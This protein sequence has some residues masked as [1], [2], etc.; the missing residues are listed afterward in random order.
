MGAVR[1]ILLRA[2][3]RRGNQRQ[4]FSR[5]A[6][7][8]RCGVVCQDEPSVPLSVQPAPVYTPTCSELR[9]RGTSQCRIC[10]T[11]REGTTSCRS[12][13]RRLCAR[14]RC[15]LPAACALLHALTHRAQAHGLL[16]RVGWQVHLR[17]GADEDARWEL[18]QTGVVDARVSFAM[19]RARVRGH[20]RTCFRARL[21]TH[22]RSTAVPVRLRVHPHAAR[23]VKGVVEPI[24]RWCRA[25]HGRVRMRSR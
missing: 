11:M 24:G 2:H 25:G 13:R 4:Q 10:A 8:G 12:I 22:T 15:V 3:E 7:R 1:E 5:Y 19:L 17:C 14:S 23:R 18:V 9:W 21:R 6:Q 16:H 20:T